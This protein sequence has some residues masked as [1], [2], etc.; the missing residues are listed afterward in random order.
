MINL[1]YVVNVARNQGPCNV[2][3]NLVSALP[4]SKYKLHLVTL[5]LGNDSDCVATFEKAGAKVTA[6]DYK[7]RISCLIQVKRDL[8]AY[9]KENHIDI[10]HSHTLFSDISVSMVKNVV[11][12]TTIHNR[13]FE[14]YRYL[15]G[16]FWG[17]W[18]AKAHVRIFKKFNNCICCSKSVYEEQTKYLSNLSVVQNGIC[19]RMATE[20]ITRKDLGI[21]DGACVFIFVG[22]LSKRKNV[23]KMIEE[24]VKNHRTDDCLLI[25]GEGEELETCK[26]KADNNVKF[27]GFVNNPSDYYAISDIYISA[28]LSEGLSLSQLESLSFG[29]K[30]L[31][32]DIPSHCEVVDIHPALGKTFNENNFADA[33]VEVVQNNDVQIKQKI[34][35][36]FEEYFSV[37]IMAGKYDDIYVSFMESR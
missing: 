30:Q 31:V 12:L 11:K 23:V 17:K 25:L 7:N 21:S 27:I 3:Y 1:C 37:K 9:C 36:I 34:Q 26:E 4:H 22:S 14:D 32:S 16:Q 13:T 29:L 19:A 8:T 24:F 33:Y 10:I 18:I 5:Y 20:N 2:I 28:S 35:A 15:F 6:F